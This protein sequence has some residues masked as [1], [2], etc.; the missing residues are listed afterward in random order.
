MA[1][2]SDKS[3]ILESAQISF[4]EASGVTRNEYIFQEQYEAVPTVTFGIT[5]TQGDMVVARIV[6]ITTQRVVIDVTAP[7]DGQVD[8]QVIQVLDA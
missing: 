3:I 7:F 5:T 4:T 8:I 1:T 6:E 2:I